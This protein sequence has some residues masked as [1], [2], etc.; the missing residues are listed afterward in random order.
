MQEFLL[1]QWTWER[2]S[3]NHLHLEA[4]RQSTSEGWLVGLGPAVASG[5]LC[6]DPVFL[7]GWNI[8]HRVH[9]L[10][11]GFLD[12]SSHLQGGHLLRNGGLHSGHTACWAAPKTLLGPQ[13]AGRPT[14]KDLDRASEGPT[15]QDSGQTPFGSLCEVFVWDSGGVCGL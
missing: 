2:G 3:G 13:L 5:Q 11:A 1:G 7:Q 15:L 4:T 8:G 14:R 6:H 12:C 10:A 9:T